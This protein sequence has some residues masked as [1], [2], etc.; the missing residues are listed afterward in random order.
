MVQTLANNA[1][2]DSINKWLMNGDELPAEGAASRAAAES[3]RE[4]R[5]G[6][7]D[8]GVAGDREAADGG[9]R[10]EQTYRSTRG[11]K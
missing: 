9:Q 8:Y 1:T 4:Q 11:G 3:S 6:G 7:A 10:R 2:N 5:G